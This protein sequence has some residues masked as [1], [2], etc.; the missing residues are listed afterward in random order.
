MK[1]RFFILL[2]LVV[3]SFAIL[4][5]A[6]TCGTS[7]GEEAS[8]GEEGTQGITI[9]SPG[10]ITVL[11]IGNTITVTWTSE[12]V[13]NVKIE[14]SY[15][16]MAAWNTIEESLDA[17]VGTYTWTVAGIPSTQCYLRIFDAED[18]DP[19]VVLGPFTLEYTVTYTL[20][21]FYT[22]SPVSGIT[23]NVNGSEYTSDS[24][25]KITV[26][27]IDQADPNFTAYFVSSSMA[28]AQYKL[29][30]DDSQLYFRFLV[31]E[32]FSH[33][34]FLKP[35][36][37]PS[38]NITVSGSVEG[39]WTDVFVY[40]ADDG[41]LVDSYSGGVVAA[42]VGPGYNVDLY[43]TGLYY[44]IVYDSSSM[45]TLYYRTHTVSA[46]A[47]QTFDLTDPGT[48]VSFS[49]TAD[50]RADVLYGCLLIGGNYTSAGNGPPMFSSPIVGGT[51]NATFP[52]N[53]G[54]TVWLAM[55]ASSETPPP[56]YIPPEQYTSDTSDLNFTLNDSGSTVPDPWNANPQF[57]G[58]TLTWIAAG[59]ATEYVIE[60]SV[61]ET[62]ALFAFTD[63]TS[64]SIPDD[65][66]VDSIDYIS[67]YPVWADTGSSTVVC[68]ASIWAQCF[69]SN[70]T[71]LPLDIVSGTIVDYRDTL[72][73]YWS[74]GD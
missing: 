44:F 50:S 48:T 18:G 23:M 19:V 27:I 63:G 7:S 5:T 3:F 21:D 62:I 65:I 31:T 37:P 45:T 54:D 72:S 32:S 14:I 55:G 33:T 67:M 20:K 57:D 46:S 40:S 61:S 13:M 2:T 34:L 35:Y 29:N 26:H 59:N 64:F 11:S 42:S 66:T 51:I 15:N 70:V 24:S 71:L 47:T 58:T 73:A 39:S 17:S 36:S 60:F 25:G 41:L 22:G 10:E 30:Y 4:F 12:N 8:S 16:N 52:F 28:E 43:R 68:F 49:G 69:D 56:Y 38:P 53:S 9:T 6:V 1:N 74:G